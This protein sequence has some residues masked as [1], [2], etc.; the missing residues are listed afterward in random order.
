MICPPEVQNT[1]VISFHCCISQ[2]SRAEGPLYSSRDINMQ[3]ERWDVKKCIIYDGRWRRY[4]TYR[5]AHLRL[6]YHSTKAQSPQIIPSGSSS[7]SY[8]AHSNYVFVFFVYWGE[9]VGGGGA[10]EM[11]CCIPFK[12]GSAFLL[13][14]FW[15]INACA[16]N[17]LVGMCEICEQDA[18]A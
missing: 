3:Q 9:K 16:S 17:F 4:N 1:N 10:V 13:W 7:Q 6:W 8:L 18:A 15:H 5:K 14:Q 2:S 11:A 12:S